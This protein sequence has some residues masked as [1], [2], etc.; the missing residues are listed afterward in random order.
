MKD[1][2]LIPNMTQLLYPTGKWY[3]PTTYAKQPPGYFTYS[4][5]NFGMVGT[6]IEK[7]TNIRFD[8]FA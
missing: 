5:L 8:I 4:N 3:S 2:L 1:P 6:M 7:L